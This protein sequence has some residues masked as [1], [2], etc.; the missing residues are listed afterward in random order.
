MIK[1]L[2]RYSVDVRRIRENAHV[3]TTARIN[4][5]LVLI[6]EIMICVIADYT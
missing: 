5:V 2:I 1:L 6:I 3:T 4:I